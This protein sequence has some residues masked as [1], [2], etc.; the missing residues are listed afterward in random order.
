MFKGGAPIV[1]QVLSLAADHVIKVG[2]LRTQS[3]LQTIAPQDWATPEDAHPSA[4]VYDGNRKRMVS[5]KHRPA[6][7]PH[8]CISDQ[9]SAHQSPLVAALL[10]TTFDVVG[11]PFLPAAL[12][13]LW[14][15]RSPDLHFH[16]MQFVLA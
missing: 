12:L 7:W 5:I 9:S 4:M 13:L 15:S 14:R 10:N 16:V 1:L 8:K 3:C 6:A 2:D 11:C